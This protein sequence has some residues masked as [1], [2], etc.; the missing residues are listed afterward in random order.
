ML[1][2]ARAFGSMRYCALT[3]ANRAAGLLP[4][5]VEHLRITYDSRWIL[6]SGAVW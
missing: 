6:L 5:L 4:V 1:D 2:I 3:A